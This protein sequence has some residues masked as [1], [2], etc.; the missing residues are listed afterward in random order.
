[1]KLNLN[2]SRYFKKLCTWKVSCNGRNKRFRNLFLNH[3]ALKKS[4]IINCLTESRSPYQ[5]IEYSEY[6]LYSITMDWL[7]CDLQ[8]WFSVPLNKKRVGEMRITQ[9]SN[10]QYLSFEKLGIIMK[11]SLLLITRYSLQDDDDVEF[12]LTNSIHNPKANSVVKFSSTH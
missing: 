6:E 12:F 1:M 2:A 9:F 10:R 5:L 4:P 7:I 8:P 11:L 3:S